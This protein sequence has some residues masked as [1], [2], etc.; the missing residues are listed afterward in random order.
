[1]NIFKLCAAILQ[2]FGHPKNRCWHTQLNVCEK[3]GFPCF[4]YLIQIFGVYFTYKISSSW[5]GKLCTVL[6]NWRFHTKF[7][8]SLNWMGPGIRVLTRDLKPSLPTFTSS[9]TSPPSICKFGGF[10]RI[11]FLKMVKFKLFMRGWK[12]AVS[13]RLYKGRNS[14][15]LL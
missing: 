12:K 9:I 13:R 6:N 15:L 5:C 8:W 11:I 14:I 3:E 2:D 1:M 10:L 4:L 7:S